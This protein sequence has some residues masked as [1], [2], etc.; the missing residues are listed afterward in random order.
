VT[1]DDFR[2]AALT[3]EGAVEASHMNHPDFRV[4]GKI[5]ASLGYPD[6]TWGVLMLT[7]DQQHGLCA[8]YPETFTPL[9]NSWG[10]KGATWV[11]L[12]TADPAAV[13]EG[14]AVA[15]RNKMTAP[16]QKQPSPARSKHRVR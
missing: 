16:P 2:Q 13:D 8:A 14:L 15:W 4:N 11:R 5:F 3:L 9:N 10:S 7:P 12:A 1:P 6:K